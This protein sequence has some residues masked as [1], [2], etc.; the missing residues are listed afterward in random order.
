MCDCLL[1]FCNQA[2]AVMVIEEKVLMKASTGR[3]TYRIIIGRW[4]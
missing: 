3:D 1:L 4:Q 2:F